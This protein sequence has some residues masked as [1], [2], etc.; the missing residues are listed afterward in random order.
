MSIV[1][2]YQQ[3]F[4]KDL[5]NL[6]NSHE[7]A[8]ERISIVSLVDD[9]SAPDHYG[10]VRDEF[11]RIQKKQFFLFS[12][13]FSVLID[14]A[15]HSAARHLHEDFQN[16]AQYPKLVGILSSYW[17]NL[18]PSL[19]LIASIKHSKNLEDLENYFEDLA[20]FILND[21]QKFFYCQ[22]PKY[23]KLLYSNEEIKLNLNNIFNE[24][25]RAMIWTDVPKSI[26]S[27]QLNT[28][29]LHSYKTIIDKLNTELKK[30]AEGLV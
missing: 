13:F 28:N 11:N 6:M 24:I 18:H 19:L 30:V 25:S 2:Y 5:I 9:M 23:T 12:F 21:Y 1:E 29:E 8:K 16:I 26:W 17:S 7:F 10:V 4:S 27:Y 15:I 20:K 22:F 14:Q 3:Q